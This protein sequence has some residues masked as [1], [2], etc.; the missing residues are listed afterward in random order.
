MSIAV[1]FG[2]K[3]VANRMPTVFIIPRV[4]RPLTCL[5]YCHNPYLTI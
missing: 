3:A 4:G 5:F 2:W 1:G